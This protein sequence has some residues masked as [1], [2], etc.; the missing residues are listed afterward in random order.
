VQQQAFLGAIG[1]VDRDPMIAMIEQMLQT[2][3]VQRVSRNE[4]G[5]GARAPQ[6]GEVGLAG[7]FWAVQ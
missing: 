5:R 3:L 2:G 7:A 6:M 4:S 1:I